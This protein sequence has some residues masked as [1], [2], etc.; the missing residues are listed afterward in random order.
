M[1]GAKLAQW[2]DAGRLGFER[3]D[4]AAKDSTSEFAEGLG[5]DSA[6]LART[7]VSH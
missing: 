3:F 1:V 5:G 2:G 4:A 6:R 7:I